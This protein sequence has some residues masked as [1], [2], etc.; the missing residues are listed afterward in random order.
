MRWLLAVTLC[1]C[2]SNPGVAGRPE[3]AAAP[4]ARTAA[5]A[6]DVAIA[7]SGGANALW[8]DAASSRLY[9]TNSSSS[10]LMTWTDAEG[11]RDVCALPAD[12]GGTSLGGIVRR[13][14]GTLLIANFGFGTHG[15]IFAVTA[16]VASALTGLEPT[17]RRV[18]LAQDAAG[19]VYSAY[20][21]G[22]RGKPTTGGVATVAIAG[23]TA[24]E[25]EIA[26][27]FQKV[28]GVV[29]TPTAL[30]ISD[31]TDRTIYK[32]EMPGHAVSK[33]ATAPSVDLLAILPNGDL[34]TGGGSTISRITQ[35]GES[36]TLR[37][38]FEQVRG[39]AYDDAGKRLFVIDHSL[40]I[41]VP[42][43]LR[44]IHLPQC[45]AGA[46]GLAPAAS[47]ET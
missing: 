36:S 40:T 28:V 10:A 9:L 14:D 37:D 22:G 47:G 42:D 21:V 17:R 33:V 46:T 16:G 41:G 18:G 32:I 6:A 13:G 19:S 39:I 3:P 23:T 29:A 20:F 26:S 43:K 11:L 45:C 35:S 34:L 27:G 25:V 5:P 24:S 12:A 15:G 1:G 44:V 31:Q 4:A 8:W 38:G 30:F 2:A 7:L